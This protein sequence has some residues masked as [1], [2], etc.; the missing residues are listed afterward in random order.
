[1][2]FIIKIKYDN[3]Y[4]KN[5]FLGYDS[6]DSKGNFREI[7][8]T[9]V[10][11]PCPHGRAHYSQCPHCMGWNSPPLLNTNKTKLPE[12]NTW[13]PGAITPIYVRWLWLDRILCKIFNPFKEIK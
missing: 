2:L 3:R 6:H 1:M 7:Y 5:L 10:K 11:L 13:L 4:N 12:W 8:M 9:E